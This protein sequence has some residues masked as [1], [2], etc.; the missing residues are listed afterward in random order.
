MRCRHARGSGVKRF[1]RLSLRD[2]SLEI[3]PPDFEPN[4]PIRGRLFRLSRPKCLDLA[5]EIAD[6]GQLPSIQALKLHV[7]SSDL[8]LFLRTGLLRLEAK[9]EIGR[10]AQRRANPSDRLKV[11]LVSAGEIISEALRLQ[12][13]APSGLGSGV[14]PRQPDRPYDIALAQYAGHKPLKLPGTAKKSGRVYFTTW[15]PIRRLVISY[16]WLRSI[17]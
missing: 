3:D 8:H 12:L 4:S 1:A 5:D 9:E 10:Q 17:S 6:E 15:I 11:R 7:D 16:N 2:L 13:Q 14:A